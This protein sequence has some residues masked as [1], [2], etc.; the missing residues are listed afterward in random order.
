M[1]D[2]RARER[3]EGRVLLLTA[4]SRGARVATDP[5]QFSD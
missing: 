4:D 3:L 1:D 2:S 5:E